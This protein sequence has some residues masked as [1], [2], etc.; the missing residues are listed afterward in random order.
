MGCM[1][2]ALKRYLDEKRGRRSQLAEA[3]GINPAAIA[4][5]EKV[6]A[7]RMGDVS[8]ETGIPLEEL[9]PDI[10]EA[11]NGSENAS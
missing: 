5:W 6:P 1:I 3:L 10:F 8:R 2:T 9:R 11:A 7:E 4:Q